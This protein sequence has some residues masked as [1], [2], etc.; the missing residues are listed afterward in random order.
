MMRYTGLDVSTL[1]TLPKS[2]VRGNRVLTYRLK[3]KAE[4]WTVIP[5]WVADKLQSAPHDGQMHFFWSGA[6]L[7]HTR[8][9]KWFSRL[10]KLLDL[11]GLP[12]RTPHNFR[13]HFA[14][15]HLLS[16][17]PI[18]DVARL[19]GHN[20]VNVTLR[21][22]AAWVERRQ[23]QLEAHQQRVWSSD[24]LHLKMTENPDYQESV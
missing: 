14:V 17:T 2:A 9:S 4:V 11:A 5:Q 16:G 6:G 1:L 7:P 24:P 3:N 20:D 22:Y 12:H 18:E 13:H 15:E 10:R 19:L 23:A 21:S 8:A